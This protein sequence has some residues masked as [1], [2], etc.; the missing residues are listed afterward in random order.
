MLTCGAAKRKDKDYFKNI[1]EQLRDG[2]Y[3][4]LLY[5]LQEMDLTNF[6]PRDAPH[7]KDL[8][9]QISSSLEGIENLWHDCLWGG[10][11][12]GEVVDGGSAMLSVTR[13]LE[14]CQKQHRREWKDISI[15]E[16]TDFFS[17]MNFEQEKKRLRKKGERQPKRWSIPPL[18]DCR[19]KWDQLRTKT[20]W[21]D[22][23]GEWGDDYVF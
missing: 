13:L 4:N 11:I 6:D 10:V 17:K 7:T 16:I 15:R 2:G 12:P 22:D 5:H 3:A 14:W 18:K 21:P 23:D 1:R 20:N 8:Q 9:K 19:E